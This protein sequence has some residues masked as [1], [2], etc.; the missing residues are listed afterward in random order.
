MRKTKYTTDGLKDKP[1]S[2]IVTVSTTLDASEH[3]REIYIHTY[4]FKVSS[5][6]WSELQ[7]ELRSEVEVAP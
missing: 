1:H 7:M 6:V 5:E 3:R 2:F 4:I